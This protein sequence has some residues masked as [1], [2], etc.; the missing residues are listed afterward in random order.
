M[1]V[2]NNGLLGYLSTYGS[3]WSAGTSSSTNARYMH[4]NP[5]NTN[6]ADENLRIWGF[7][8]RSVYE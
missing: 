8:L 5:S 3:Y 6:T 4:L 2:Y 7:N 1:L